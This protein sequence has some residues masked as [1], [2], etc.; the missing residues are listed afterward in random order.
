MSPFLQQL[1][2][3]LVV[4]CIIYV[5]FSRKSLTNYQVGAGCSAGIHTDEGLLT[6]V[7]T[8]QSTD[9]SN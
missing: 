1:T 3:D 7:R 4:F 9:E 5:S 8:E 2:S 6:G